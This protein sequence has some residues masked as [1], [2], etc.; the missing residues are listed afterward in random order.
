MC[1]RL[2]KL[3]QNNVNKLLSSSPTRRFF[4]LPLPICKAC[5]EGKHMRC[6]LRKGSFKKLN[7]F[8][9]LIILTFSA[10]EIPENFG[11]E[12]QFGEKIKF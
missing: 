12:K 1:K 4:F 3:T 8:I 7:T 9:L 6:R 11:G 5:D 10:V 2:E